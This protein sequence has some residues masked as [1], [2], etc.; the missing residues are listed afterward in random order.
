MG[1]SCLKQ[2]PPLPHLNSHTYKD[3]ILANYR[4]NPLLRKNDGLPGESAQGIK[5]CCL[6]EAGLK[7]GEG[8]AGD[9]F[10]LTLQALI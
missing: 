2:V 6:V 9:H 1:A 4:I 3:V 8:K 7:G 10:F 5:H